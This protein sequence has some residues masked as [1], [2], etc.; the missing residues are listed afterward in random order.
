M[1]SLVHKHIQYIAE[2]VRM[3]AIRGWFVCK[4]NGGMKDHCDQ[5]SLDLVSLPDHMISV[6]QV[7]SATYVRAE[8]W[9]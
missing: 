3:T 8:T 4:K 1:L 5:Q 9:R 2:T 6:I 7:N